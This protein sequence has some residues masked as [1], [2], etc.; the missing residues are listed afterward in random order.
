[1]SYIKVCPKCTV[2]KTV[3]G[4]SK[5]KTGKGGLSWQCKTCDENYQKVYR[6]LNKQKAAEYKKQ[7]QIVNK[8]KLNAIS[9][10]FAENN[11]E[12]TREHKRKYNERRRILRKYKYDNDPFERSVVCFRCGI[13]RAFKSKGWGKQG[14]SKD[15]LGCDYETAKQYIENRFKEG[16]SWANYGKFGWHVDHIIP[17][18]SAKTLADIKKLCHYTNLQPLWWLENII[19][20]DKIMA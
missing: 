19:K 6:V 20:S 9:K 13:T 4:F 17:L 5:K 12:Y 11:K 16:M 1:M 2:E 18:A 7:Y 15:I 8:E 10:K 14:K 3:D